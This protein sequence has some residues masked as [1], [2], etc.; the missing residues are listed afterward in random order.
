MSQELELKKISFHAECTYAKTT[1]CKRVNIKT[2]SR[3]RKHRQ[4]NRHAHKR[5]HRPLQHTSLATV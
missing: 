3:T 4:S 5:Q 2:E 1:S